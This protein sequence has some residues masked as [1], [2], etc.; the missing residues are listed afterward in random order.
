MQKTWHRGPGVRP[1][2]WNPRTQGTEAE[3]CP[4]FKASLS[5][6]QVSG[7]KLASASEQDIVLKKNCHA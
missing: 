4:K 1:H 3:D 6:Y 2:A 7:F 5:M